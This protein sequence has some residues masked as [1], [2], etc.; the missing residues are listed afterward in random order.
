MKKIIIL[1]ILITSIGF[2]QRPA[3]E[4]LANYTSGVAVNTALNRAMAAV[5]GTGVANQI[6]YWTGTGTIGYLSVATYPSLAELAFVKGVTSPIQTQLNGKAITAHTHTIA[7]VTGLQA[8]LD[9]KQATLVS[10]TN[11]KTINSQTLLG[12]GNIMIASDTTG[13][14]VMVDNI[15]RSLIIGETIT[16]TA[17]TLDSMIVDFRKNTP[18]RLN[19]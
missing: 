6:T 9:A 4:I 10:G 1:L 2:A 18:L 19:K 13:L 17:A 8:A 5:T 3:D 15:V 14:W 12:T 16:G 7:N 11:I